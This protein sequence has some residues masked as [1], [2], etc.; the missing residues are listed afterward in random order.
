MSVKVRRVRSAA[1]YRLVERYKPISGESIGTYIQ[2]AVP[3][4]AGHTMNGT[5][6]PC[7]QKPYKL[8]PDSLVVH[9]VDRH[10]IVA[11]LQAKYKPLRDLTK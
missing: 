3:N 4:M 1:I 2:V 10:R 9:E 5:S 6:C 7:W 11:R 8:E